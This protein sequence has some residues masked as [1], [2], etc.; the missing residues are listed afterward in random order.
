MAK[1]S[2]PILG[3]EYSMQPMRSGV[4]DSQPV[5]HSTHKKYQGLTKY[6]FRSSFWG[7]GREGVGKMTS[8]CSLFQHPPTSSPSRMDGW[9]DG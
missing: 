7:G 3:I 9:M 1:P 4:M 2:M 6:H 5:S 8:V